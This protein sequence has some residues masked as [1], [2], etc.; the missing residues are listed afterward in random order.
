MHNSICFIKI[1]EPENYLIENNALLVFIKLK[2]N[3]DYVQVIFSECTDIVDQFYVIWDHKSN[4]K[5]L[6]DLI[7]TGVTIKYENLTNSVINGIYNKLFIE[8]FN[9]ESNYKKLLLFLNE[10]ITVNFLLDKIVMLVRVWKVKKK[11]R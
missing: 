1:S 4:K 2:M 8:T 11:G 7:N 10:V 5:L 6:K 3:S 9:E